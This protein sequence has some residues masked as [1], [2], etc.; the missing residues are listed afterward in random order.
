MSAGAAARGA[1]FLGDV[2]VHHH[3]LR[4]RLP[5]DQTRRLIMI[6][7]CVADENDLRVVVS[8]TE[9]LDTGA[10]QRD[11]LLEIRIDQNVSLR[12][13]DQINREVGGAD[14]V[15]VSRDLE[16]REASVPV[17]TTLRQQR[18]RKCYERKKSTSDHMSH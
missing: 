16:C 12:G 17:Q 10:N 9:L 13:M 15:K 1:L 2:C 14:V 18:S 3:Q 8:E 5:P 6:A 4:V 11:V 7:M